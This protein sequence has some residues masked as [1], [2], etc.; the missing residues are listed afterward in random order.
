MNLFITVLTEGH[1]AAKTLKKLSDNHFHGSVLATNSFRHALMES[2]EP[3]PCFGG[4]SKVV[5]QHE[6]YTRPMIFVVVKD[7]SEVQ[8]LAKLV[9]EAVGGI[10]GKG[11]MYTVPVTFM[12]GLE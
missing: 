6:E 12:E 3:L 10:K 7:D 5:N 8:T 1:Y 9:N 2:I 11:F 4:I